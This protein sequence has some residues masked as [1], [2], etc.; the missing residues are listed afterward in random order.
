MRII[1]EFDEDFTSSNAMM[2][3]LE[4][5]FEREIELGKIKISIVR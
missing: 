3:T 2:E 1:L 4:I 5:L